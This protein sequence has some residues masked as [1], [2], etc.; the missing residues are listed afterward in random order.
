M[1]SP[2]FEAYIG[3]ARL[4][5]QLWRLLLG[6]VLI[7]FIYAA[8]TGLIF[9][10]LFAAVGPMGFFAW[11]TDVVSMN[12]PV[13]TLIVLTTFAGLALGPILAA[14]V[15]HLR[16]PST[17][18]GPLGDTLRGFALAT[19]TV[20]AVLLP[21][22][23]LGALISPPMENLPLGEWL[24]YLPLAIAL[25]LMQVTAEE[26][27]FRGYLQQQL[28]ARF[29]ARLIWMGLPAA[30]FAALH[31]DPDMGQSVWLILAATFVFGLIAADLTELTGSLGA[32]IG[33][34]FANNILALLVITLDGKI[35]GLALYV[36]PYTADD[37]S[38]LMI[39]TGLDILIL[40]AIWR[41]LRLLLNR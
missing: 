34:H 11:M 33:V 12:L 4:Y 1:R 21:F 2:E 27:V 38:A 29:R 6:V 24:G 36:T 26:L 14:P 19:I 35:T 8:T 15:C 23:A 25:V 40:L 39:A 22:L 31:Y 30:V 17:L 13:P 28:A 7:L 9:W 32:A 41:L 37:T 18:F 10:G 16:P 20:F 3:P 5:P